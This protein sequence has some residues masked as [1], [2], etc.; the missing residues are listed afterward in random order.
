MHAFKSILNYEFKIFHK[1]E[2]EKM[3]EVIEY[4]ESLIFVE[5]NHA[6]IVLWYEGMKQSYIFY[7]LEEALNEFKLKIKE[8]KGE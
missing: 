7:T 3:N 2:E 8:S 6:R 4:G 5:S 1:K